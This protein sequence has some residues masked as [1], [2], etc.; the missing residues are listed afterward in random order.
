M[1]QVFFGIWKNGRSMS[2]FYLLK[3][4][5]QGVFV[6]LLV[7][8]IAFAIINAAPGDPAMA[9][10]GDQVQRLTQDE[11]ERINRAY[12]ADEPAVKRYLAWASSVAKGDFGVS[13]RQGRPVLE[14][15]LERLPN[16]LMLVFGAISVILAVSVLFGFLAASENTAGLR[17]V[18][19]TASVIFASV[20]PFWFALLGIIVFSLWLGWLPSGGLETIGNGSVSDRLLHMVMPM[21]VMALTHAGMYARFLAEKVEVERKNYYVQAMRANGLEEN[22]IRRWILKS[23]SFS[24]ISYLGTT[25]PGFFGGSAIVETVFA[26]PGLGMLSVRAALTRDYP[27]LMGTVMLSGLVVVICILLTDLL[28]IWLNPRIRRA[29]ST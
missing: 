29:S 3:R 14:I 17:M 25:L 24:Y 9:L 5:G 27:L 8:I 22:T 6:L 23:A 7:S 1:E 11:R 21:A 13:Y 19:S 26:W 28:V 18:L 10:Y 20:H 2:D 16:T 12:G 4:A 15:I